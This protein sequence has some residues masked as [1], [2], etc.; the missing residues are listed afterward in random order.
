MKNLHAWLQDLLM[1]VCNA[2]DALSISEKKSV[3][4]FDMATP[5]VV[6]PIWCAMSFIAEWSLTLETRKLGAHVLLLHDVI[7]DTRAEL[8]DGT[9]DEVVLLVNEMTF[10]GGFEEERCTVWER[11]DFCILLKLYDKVSNLFDAAWMHPR[12]KA[13]YKAYVAELIA[14]VKEKYGDL[15]IIGFAESLIYSHEEV[16][17]DSH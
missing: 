17:H 7:E 6:H 14:F 15:V 4:R 3:R 1:F 9:P 5:Y 10:D 8:P 16:F 11:S 2:H 13:V 12:K